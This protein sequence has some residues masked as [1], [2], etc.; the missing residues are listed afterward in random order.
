MR[1]ITDW[2][3]TD[4]K[5]RDKGCTQQSVLMKE[6]NTISLGVTYSVPHGVVINCIK[7]DKWTV[8]LSS[9]D[10]NSANNEPQLSN[11]HV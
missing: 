4:V 7:K 11:S 5:P 1:E 3:P 9:K 8:T 10:N 2:N 6:H